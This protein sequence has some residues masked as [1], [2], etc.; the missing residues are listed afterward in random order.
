[1][2]INPNEVY[3]DPRAKAAILMGEQTPEKEQIASKIMNE[4]LPQAMESLNRPTGI[5][6][7]QAAP[8]SGK[9][10]VDVEGL[11]KQGLGPEEFARQKA[12]AERQ[13]ISNWL[14]INEKEPVPW[15]KGLTWGQHIDSILTMKGEVEGRKAV[16]QIILQQIKQEEEK[17]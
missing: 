2:A 7:A 14:L 4:G 9:G 13:S 16:E 3:T 15:A 6:A 1:M 8:P 10:E 11:L 17:D 5:Q 12:F